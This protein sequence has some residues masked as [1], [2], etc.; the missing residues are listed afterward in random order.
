[1]REVEEGSGRIGRRKDKDEE[2]SRKEG[3]REK[4]RIPLFNPGSTISSTCPHFHT[5]AVSLV[6]SHLHKLLRLCL[7]FLT[8]VVR[9]GGGRI[10]AD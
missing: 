4:A 3:H 8:G 7:N 10:A 5:V 1:M 2:K 6:L 9:I